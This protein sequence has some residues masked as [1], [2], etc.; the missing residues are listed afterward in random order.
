MEP[1]KRKRMSF[2]PVSGRVVLTDPPVT[3]ATKKAAR[4]ADVQAEVGTRVVR[5]MQAGTIFEIETPVVE[6]RYLGNYREPST[7][8]P[9]IVQTDDGLV[10]LI[11]PD[12]TR[13][14]LGGGAA[15]TL[16]DVLNNGND[17][18]EERITNLG[19]P[20]FSGDAA[21]KDYVDGEIENAA[22]GE[23]V[24]MDFA[25]WQIV[26]GVGTINLDEGNSFLQYTVIQQV[27]VMVEVYCVF[28]AGTA[29]ESNE[30]IFLNTDELP[31][32]I[33]PFALM[34]VG[35]V[36]NVGGAL[37]TQVIEQFGPGSYWQW[38]STADASP[39]GFGGGQEL[40]PTSGL[41]GRFTYLTNPV[42]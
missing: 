35:K 17:A 21:T 24:T 28:L 6:S 34:G 20:I 5:L 33:F 41:V 1:V 29:G 22:L 13:S 19:N 4:L 32:P 15:G 18:N 16:A 10:Y 36:E 2:D 40:G 37:A 23:I 31:D 25:D 30:V 14:L 27:L 12:G 3:Q 42:T 38:L 8:L 9:G 7:D 26:Q 11:N 39:L